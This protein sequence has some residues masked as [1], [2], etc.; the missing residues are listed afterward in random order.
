[1][2]NYLLSANMDYLINYAKQ[3]FSQHNG[4]HLNSAD[5]KPYIWTIDATFYKFLTNGTIYFRTK[6]IF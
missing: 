6:S 2:S 3:Q 4:L 1:M 5:W